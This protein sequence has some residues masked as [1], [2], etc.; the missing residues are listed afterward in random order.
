MKAWC[1]S[2]RTKQELV[3]PKKIKHNGRDAV[4]GT[5]KKCKTEI[6]SYRVEDK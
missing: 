4:Q 2:C 1:H 6:I 3:S 5:C